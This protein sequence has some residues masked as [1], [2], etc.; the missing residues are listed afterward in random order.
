MSLS[1][2]DYDSLRILRTKHNITRDQYWENQAGVLGNDHF[3]VWYSAGRTAVTH[4]AHTF[5]LLMGARSKFDEFVGEVPKDV[6]V[7]LIMADLDS[8][9]VLRGREWWHYSDTRGDTIAFQPVYNLYIRKL[10]KIAVPHE[11]YQWA[12]RK[13]TN[14]RAPHWLEEGFASYLSDEAPVLYDQVFEFPERNEDMSVEQ[15]EAILTTEET[16]SEMRL[17]CY[18]SY[19]MVE[20]LLK[21][22]G[23]EK[24]VALILQLGHET[25]LD[26]ASRAALGTSFDVALQVATDYRLTIP[27][28]QTEREQ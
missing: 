23:G 27:D 15:I 17:A 5:D 14:N 1:E 8:Y 16:K 20:N 18:R 13:I 28:R 7:V 26:D 3:E 9:G 22:Y 21:E 6:A 12:V 11:Y 2:A 10:D 19:L 24:I 4:G 25:N